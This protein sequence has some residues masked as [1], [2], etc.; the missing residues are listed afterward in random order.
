M[1]MEHFSATI[2]LW[3]IVD[4]NVVGLKYVIVNTRYWLTLHQENGA[5]LFWRCRFDRQFYPR[6][7]WQKHPRNNLNWIK[8]LIKWQ[9]FSDF[10]FSHSTVHLCISFPSLVSFFFFKKKTW[11]Y[12]TCN[13]WHYWV[14]KN[15]PKTR[16]FETGLR[17]TSGGCSRFESLTKGMVVKEW[18]KGERE[19]IAYGRQ[20]KLRGLRLRRGC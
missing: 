18:R 13:T 7:S 2:L 9:I 5:H 3:P 17:A 6:E 16:L 10:I 19:G 11:I 12:F 1:H 14:T 4:K 20:D 15:A 8:C